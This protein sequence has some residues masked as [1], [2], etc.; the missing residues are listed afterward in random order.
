MQ[1]GTIL[2]AHRTELVETSNDRELR[3]WIKN[4]PRSNRRQ[5][6]RDLEPERLVGLWDAVGTPAIAQLLGSVG[7]HDISRA[8]RELS[9]AQ[10]V[11]L[12]SALH[13]DRTANAL[14][15][16]SDERSDMIRALLPSEYREAVDEL[17]SRPA[18]SAGAT[19]PPDLVWLPAHLNAATGIEQLRAESIR[20][21]AT[22][23]DATSYLYL[24]DDDSKLVGVVSFHELVTA[25]PR[26]R[27]ADIANPVSTSVEPT[28]DREDAANHL[29]EHDIKALPVVDN[30]SPRG[31][32]TAE[33]AAEIM[34]TETTEDFQRMSA[35]TDLKSTLKDAS[36]WMLYRSRVGW[37]VIL[38]F[39]NIFSGAGIAYYESLIEQ[40][41]VLVF[42]LPLLI[43]SGGNAG[44]QSAT[45][46]VRALAT[47]QAH[48]R[49]WFKMLGKELAVALLLGLSMAVAV[50]VI[51]FW[52]GGV[53]VALVV[54]LTMVL[55]VLVGCLIGM[56]LPFMLTKFNM[57]PAS[58]SAPLITSIC[59]GLGVLIYFF[60]AS[61]ILL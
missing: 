18:E 58:A 54:S 53:E 9:E 40:V 3:Q 51:G 48:M 19:M 29:Y 44:S 6:L 13:F 43:D 5:Q 1:N 12:L 28:V 24:L 2:A 26:A 20:P 35:A 10:T 31:V 27:L 14:R 25:D 21:E 38:V 46:M 4:T 22:R 30:G 33:K 23:P 56:S 41:V 45:L 11:E 16:M 61:Q 50:S 37:L 34:A 57:D 59:D 52:R 15:E 55:I 60:L 36:I 8:V 47:G 49:D 39:G 42:F 7:S 32:I 17:L